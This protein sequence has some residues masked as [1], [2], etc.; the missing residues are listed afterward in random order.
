M[1]TKPIL[2]AQSQV[3]QEPRLVDNEP[4]LPVDVE[5]ATDVSFE[6]SVRDWDWEFVDNKPDDDTDDESIVSVDDVEVGVIS[7]TDVDDDSGTSI[8]WE[9]FISDVVNVGSGIKSNDSNRW[10]YQGWYIYY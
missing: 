3:T 6:F 7:A 10:I 1:K 2:Q 4:D 5:P 9:V 8:D